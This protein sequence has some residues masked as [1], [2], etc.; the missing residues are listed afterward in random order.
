MTHVCTCGQRFKQF[1]ALATHIRKLGRDHT[2]AHLAYGDIL[3]RGDPADL[4]RLEE[5]AKLI[6]AAKETNY[7]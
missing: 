1:R 6:D 3:L 4:E 5:L 2:D 7:E